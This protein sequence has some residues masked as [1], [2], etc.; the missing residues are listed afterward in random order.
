MEF[1][2]TTKSSLSYAYMKWR[3][4]LLDASKKSDQEI[5]STVASHKYM[6][7]VCQRQYHQCYY[8]QY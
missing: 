5:T 2:A 7:S 1:I 8:L 3:G 6:V 4:T